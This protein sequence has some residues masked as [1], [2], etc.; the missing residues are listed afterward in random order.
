MMAMNYDQTI[1]NLLPPLTLPQN[2]P[3]I[4][5]LSNIFELNR[6]TYQLQT[7]Y[8]YKLKSVF[9]PFLKKFMWDDQ[10]HDFYND[11]RPDPPDY[12]NFSY[13]YHDL[14]NMIQKTTFGMYKLI[15]P[16]RP[17]PPSFSIINPTYYSD[18]ITVDVTQTPPPPLQLQL[19]PPP[20]LLTRQNDYYNDK[21]YKIYSKYFYNGFYNQRRRAIIG[22]DQIEQAADIANTAAAMEEASSGESTTQSALLARQRAIALLAAPA[23]AAAPAAAAAAAAPAPAAAA[24]AAAPAAAQAAAALDNFNVV[25]IVPPLPAPPAPPYVLYPQKTYVIEIEIPI[26][27]LYYIDYILDIFTNA[28]SA[29]AVATHTDPIM[30]LLARD[31]MPSILEPHYNG[32][33]YTFN[34]AMETENIVNIRL[35]MYMKHH[36]INNA[37]PTISNCYRSMTSPHYPN[38]Q[39]QD[40]KPLFMITMDTT[41]SSFPV[42]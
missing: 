16:S 11:Y 12:K 24:A 28:C 10:M 37:Q 26:Y 4:N 25:M 8:F 41:N 29:S 1:N 42:D 9:I 38:N 27:P 40:Q 39:P 33:K 17:L 3:V 7:I 35:W 13:R 30:C 23:P 5:P 18:D 14:L 6:T 34:G 36:F 20:Q 31:L 22:T 32:V 2:P 15:S 21:K 19:Q